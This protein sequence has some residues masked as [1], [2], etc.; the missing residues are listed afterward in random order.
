M[1]TRIV[2]FGARNKRKRVPRATER[3]PRRPGVSWFATPFFSPHPPLRPACCNRGSF[4]LGVERVEKNGGIVSLCTAVSNPR[5]FS[6]F[7]FVRAHH[8]RPSPDTLASSS[9][10]QE[11]KKGSL[12]RREIQRRRRGGIVQSNFSLQRPTSTTSHPGSAKMSSSLLLSQITLHSSSSPQ[13]NNVIAIVATTTITM[14][15]SFV[16]SAPTQL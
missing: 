14:I 1:C 6:L 11:K 10:S 7:F 5:P 15:S 2:T 16:V 8:T 13:A 9:T 4:G 12:E 3:E